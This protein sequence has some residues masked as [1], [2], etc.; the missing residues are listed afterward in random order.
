MRT[1]PKAKLNHTLRDWRLSD[2]GQTTDPE[3]QDYVHPDDARP[4]SVEV[5]VKESTYA[6]V[7]L[8]GPEGEYVGLSIE[9]NKGLPVIHV[10]NREDD[11]LAHVS[12]TPRGMAVVSDNT[13][14][15]FQHHIP[16]G[17]SPY[18]AGYSDGVYLHVPVPPQD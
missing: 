10:S 15:R 14:D 5:E 18:E 8:E 3:G 11:T 17:E 7:S 1:K 6:F 4:W 9:I 2:S 16:H 12:V 13:T